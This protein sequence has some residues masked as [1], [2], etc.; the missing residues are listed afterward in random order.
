[1]IKT[2]LNRYKNRKVQAASVAL[3]LCIL[4]TL[5]YLIYDGYR[6]EIVTQQQQN[7]LGNSRSISRSIELFISDTID[8]MR[9]I[10]QDK[11]FIKSITTND[12][13]QKIITYYGAGGNEI[14]SV[15]FIDDKGKVLMRYPQG[16]SNI[17]KTVSDDIKTAAEKKTTYIGNAYFDK[18]KNIFV[19]NIYEPVIDGGKLKGIVSA[20]INL[21]VIYDK[22]I[23][24]VRIGEKGYA[25]VKDQNG[26][27]IM[28]TVKQQVGMDVIET[29]KQV[30]PDL[31]YKELEDL[32][33]SQLTGKE[34]TAIY[35]S[36]WWGDNILKKAKK[37]NAYTPVNLGDHFWIVA[38]TMSYDEIQ[39]P[40]NK[41]LVKI[42]GIVSLIVI[43]ICFFV[44]ALLRMKKNKEELEKETSYLKML[45]ETSE[46]LRKKEAE[47]YHSHKLKMIGTLAGG[48]A[49]DINNLLTPILGY[50]ELLL[51]Q[52]PK[53]GEYY[54]EIDEIYKASQ[55]GK[56]LIEQIL[57]FSRKDNGIIK[58]EPIDINEIT[59]DTIKLLKAIVPKNV[60]VNEYIKENCG[61]VMANFTQLHQ[62]IF[63]L[64]TNAYQAIK[65]NK[66]YIEISLDTVSGEEAH[67][68]A[69]T[70]P[71]GKNYA[72]ITIKDTGCGMDEETRERIF[73]PFFTT[74]EIGEGT[75][76]GLFVVQSIINKYQGTI[77]VESKEGEGSS[78]KVY[79]PLLEEQNIF[80]DE[81]KL[82]KLSYNN[83]KILV[84]D[85]NENITKLL[86][87][88]LK[89]MDCDIAI[90]TDPIRALDIFEESPK[91]FN[92]LIT[93]F[94]MPNL[95]GNEL[96]EKAKAINKD[97]KVILITGYMDKS[98]EVLEKNDTI[99][100]CISK[101]IQLTKLNETIKKIIA[102]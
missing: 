24:P 99:D 18:E 52:I 34:G 22:L 83:K 14:D 90:E 23:E 37:L 58:V 93:D 41:F 40:I 21:N 10:T 56:D 97:I 57:L 15:Y 51:M 20:A 54:E 96:A 67:E 100:A 76:L 61:L 38:L 28:H 12:Y 87:K 5:I 88:G 70:I 73:D 16:I 32:I 25:L 81:L 50:S 102:D 101:P 80:K 2:L 33:A 59:N 7:M 82:D 79:L 44:I 26:I 45:N 92:L 36:Y 17:D 1:M 94:M 91:D 86:K 13:K 47:L 11:D 19:L 98:L 60:I 48:I 9:I 27:I 78:F 53:D 65:V 63:N 74:K 66:G 43:I 42:V 71:K 4:S 46:Q 35:H 31:D 85:D 39:E 49:H 77:T 3:L 29:R 95:K 64:C 62:V 69:G 72:V 30:F 75:G 89:H 84:V 6:K 8:S 68:I 55:K